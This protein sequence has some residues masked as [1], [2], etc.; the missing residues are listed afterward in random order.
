MIR[1]DC[2]YQCFLQSWLSLKTLK[3]NS[4]YTDLVLGG[5]ESHPRGPSHFIVICDTPRWKTRAPTLKE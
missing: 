1:E 5:L 3:G 4:S 2:D